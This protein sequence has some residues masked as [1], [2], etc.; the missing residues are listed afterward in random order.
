M[1]KTKVSLRKCQRP[2]NSGHASRPCP[3]SIRMLSFPPTR[4][5]KSQHSCGCGAFPVRQA[6]VSVLGGQPY[7]PKFTERQPETEKSSVAYSEQGKP[8]CKSRRS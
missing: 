8:A 2:G 3:V 7:C 6:Q 1:M 4:D 5:P